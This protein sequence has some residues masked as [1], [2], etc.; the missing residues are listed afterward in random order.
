MIVDSTAPGQM[1][2]LRHFIRVHNVL[3]MT[4]LEASKHR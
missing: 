4:H 3:L 2:H 1:L